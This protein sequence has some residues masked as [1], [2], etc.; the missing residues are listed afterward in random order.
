M[1]KVVFYQEQTCGC[2]CGRKGKSFELVTKGTAQQ[3]VFPDG[4]VITI[5]SPSLPQY[6]VESTEE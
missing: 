1:S 2:G 6:S 5:P 4:H 3:F